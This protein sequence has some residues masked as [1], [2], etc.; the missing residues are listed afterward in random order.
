VTWLNGVAFSRRRSTGVASS[1]APRVT[2]IGRFSV[3]A[4]IGL[5]LVG[6][7]DEIVPQWHSRLRLV[8]ALLVA[9]LVTLGLDGV[10][11]SRERRRYIRHR[12]SWVIVA[13]TLVL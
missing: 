11:G 10:V 6:L 1:S 5:A 4:I 7:L 13:V 2:W 12:D 3:L 8:V 9:G